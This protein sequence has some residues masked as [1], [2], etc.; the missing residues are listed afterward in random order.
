MEGSKNRM[1]GLKKALVIMPVIILIMFL[2]ELI[3]VTYFNA[4]EHV[5]NGAEEENGISM[6]FAG[7]EGSTSTWMKRGYD[8]YGETVDLNAQ[9]M[10]VNFVNHS[11]YQIDDWQ[12]RVNITQDCLLNQAWCGTVEIHQHVKSEEKVQTLDLRN[13]SLDEITLDYLYDGDLL[14]PLSEGDYVLYDPSEDDS[15]V[16]FEKNSQLT[17]GFIVYYLEFPDTCTYEV[18]YSFHRQIKDGTNIYLI[19]ILL[20]A[21]LIAL[22]FYVV[23][24]ITYKN[25]VREM[26]IKKSGIVSLSDM[27]SIIYIIDLNTNTLMP[28]VTD[29]ESE[30]LRPKNLPASEQLRGMFEYDCIGS[31]K[32]M[33]ME[34]CD[35]STLEERLQDKNTIAFEYISSNYGWCRIR[36]FSMDRMEDAQLEKVVFTIQVI[37]DEKAQME[38]IAR[39]VDEAEH[40]SKAKSTFLANMSHEIRTPINTIIGLNTMILR[41]SKEPVTKSY[42]KSVN[43]AS[44]MLLSLINGILD[45]SKIEADKME[46]VPEEY[47][48]KQLVTDIINMVKTRTEFDRLEFFCEVSETIPDKLYGDKVRLKQ[49]IINLITNAA[50]YT[51]EGNVKLSIYGKSHDGK[52]HLLISVKD[53]GIGIREEDLGKLTERFSRFDEKRNHSIEGT[54]IGLNLVTG[55]LRLMDSELRVVSQYGEGSEFYFEVEQEVVDET[56]VG[57]IDFDMEEEEEEYQVLFTA[58]DA[59]ILVVDDNA[60]NLMVFEELLKATELQIDAVS[61]GFTALERTKEQQYDLIFMDHMMPD[62]DGVETFQKIRR[63]ADGKNTDTPVIILTANAIKGAS[64]EYRQMGFDDFLAKPIQ[65]ELLEQKILEFLNPSKVEKNKEQAAKKEKKEVSLPAIPGVDVAFGVTHTGGMN[66]YLS[67]L[68]QFVNVADTDMDELLNYTKVIK[69]DPSNLDAIRSYRIKVHAMKASANVMGAFQAYGIAALLEKAAIH[70]NV[71]EI[72]EVTPYF[73]EEWCSLKKV[74]E[75]S[76]PQSEEEKEKKEKP[77]QEVLESMLH[78]LETSMKSY[79]IKNADSLMEELKAIEWENEEKTVIKEME[80]AVANLDAEKVVLLCAKLK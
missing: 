7:K 17:M 80:I 5:L 69:K 39:R 24:D 64:E 54:G 65:P 71:R 11:D 66:S 42:A 57:Q 4:Q 45:M 21:W 75:G 73:G 77:P 78:L 1:Q 55:I 72:L 70:E 58:P 6:T 8:L 62:M 34:F 76:L 60:M 10:D 23:S 15:E 22:L 52:V 36:F 56:P 79:D 40:E 53:T 67:V 38:E 27:Y 31:Y 26:E 19:L 35:L 44:N 29:E 68:R 49:V 25:T 18:T 48:L 28:V 46:L 2:G 51:D 50:K 41:E 13:F 61:S 3:Y 59:K 33:A 63:Q 43:S 74:V 16:P 20:V 9:T 12:V 30:K 37:N 32:E 47:S 14:I